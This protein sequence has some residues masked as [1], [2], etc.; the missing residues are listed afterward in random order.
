[1]SVQNIIEK[2][3]NV[4]SAPDLTIYNV[5]KNDKKSIGFLG[6]DVPIE[7][8]ISAGSLPVPIRGN[9]NKD[10]NI[11]DQYLENGFDP[12]VRMQ[13]GQIL[14]GSFRF[15]DHLV[16]SNSSDAVIRIYYY[17]RALKQA[18]PTINLPELHFYDFLHSKLRSAN[19]YNLERTRELVMILEEWCG[20][21]ISKHDL[22]KAIEV[23][24]K[25]RRLLHRFSKLR[26]PEMPYISGVQ[27]L[28]MLSAT[29]LFPREEYNLLLEAFLDDAKNLKPI[30]GPRVFVSG[31]THEHTE[32]Y[33]LVE[34]HG[35]VIV[36]EDHDM[37]LRNFIGQIDTSVDPLE[38]IVEYYHLNRSLPSS[39]STVSERVKTLVGDVSATN[40]KGVIFFIHHADDAPSWDFPEQKKALEGMGIPVLLI[41][42]EQYKLVNK[43]E[44][45]QKLKDF[46]NELK[47]KH[48]SNRVG[49]R[50]SE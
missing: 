26:G 47:E 35:A 10:S 38:A 13:M 21:N 50:Y 16:I 2:I 12:R 31:S 6:N 44:V 19:L 40:S 25:T 33:E 5:R 27:A 3:S 43:S 32:F 30:E 39:Q 46:I 45:N 36:G 4:Y 15:L 18:E 11:A 14:D 28:Q 17:L 49:G 37:S 22:A 7:L 29:L 48:K 24:N 1:M 8:I 23:C 20:K 34:S 9:Q 41:D 42:R